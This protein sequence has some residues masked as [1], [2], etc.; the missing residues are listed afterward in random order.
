MITR[1]LYN[2]IQQQLSLGKVIVLLGPRQVGKTTLLKA[3]VAKSKRGQ[4]YNADEGD[5]KEAI[6]NATTSTQLRNIIG[7]GTRL[8]VI[9]EAQQIKGIGH[10]IKLLY[11]TF[12]ELQIILSGSSSLDLHDALDEP[13][14]GR[15]VEFHLFPL[16]HAELVADSSSL[17]EQRQLETRLIY[18][19]YPEVINNPGREREVL[20]E[21][22]NSYLYK[23]ILMFDGI[24]KSS[25][26]QKLL[27]ALSFQV[28]SEVRY[29]ELAKTVG[30]ID[31]ATVEKYLDILENMFV[32]YKLPAFS[33][34]LRNELKKGKKYYFYD[35]G[36][37]NI[38]INNFNYLEFRHD[39]GALWENHLLIERW[40]RNSYAG[41]H[42]LRYFW[43]TH[44]QAEID[45]LEEIDG[46]IHAFEFKWKKGKKRFPKSFL[47]A[48][49]DHKTAVVNR[50][51]Y[52]EFV[53]SEIE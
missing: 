52:V 36:I 28:G 53:A 46:T 34:N 11:D 9:D 15:K 5:V 18:G 22:G 12:S 1:I 2:D 39:K 17:E 7:Q 31:P 19:S 48:Y 32:I 8:V 23:D 50:E 43:R 21:L 14:T 38:L 10:K 42:V 4:W 29:Y 26:I 20:L 44:D 40:K 35:N 30:N 27:Q 47:T 33:R 37:R 45:Y 6:E 25:F 24:K 13:L 16:S 41:R 3:L 49:P 51:N